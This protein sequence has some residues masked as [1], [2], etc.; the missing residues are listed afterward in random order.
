M[1][2]GEWLLFAFVQTYKEH[3]VTLGF[4]NPGSFLPLE[5]K[6]GK[7]VTLF[8]SPSRYGQDLV[9]VWSLIAREI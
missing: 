9:Q 3:D 7:V 6:S 2:E 5:Q 4:G 1:G 8:P